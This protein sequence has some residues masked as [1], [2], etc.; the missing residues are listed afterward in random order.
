M[1]ACMR[2]YVYVNIVWCVIII[3]THAHTNLHTSVSIKYFFADVL[4]FDASLHAYTWIEFAFLCLT[5]QIRTYVHMYVILFYTAYIH[6]HHMHTCVREHIL[7][8]VSVCV[9][10]C[11]WVCTCTCVN[12]VHFFIRPHEHPLPSHTHVYN[13]CVYACMLV[14]M[15]MSTVCLVS[16]D[17]VVHVHM[18]VHAST[19]MYVCV[20]V[21]VYIYTHTQAHFHTYIAMRVSIHAALHVSVHIYAQ[22]SLNLPVHIPKPVW[23]CVIL[24]HTHILDFYKYIP[25]C[26]HA[27]TNARSACVYLHTHINAHI[28]TC[29]RIHMCRGATSSLC[30]EHLETQERNDG[31]TS[32]LRTGACKHTFPCTMSQA[33]HQWWCVLDFCG[34][35]C[36]INIV[37]THHTHS[38]VLS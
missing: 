36:V 18:C 2:A 15:Y 23:K 37:L 9:S 20:R 8:C 26:T 5:M 3:Y 1:C 7:T 38:S 28:H 34:L 17:I 6:A 30:L 24:N 13:M 31:L 19:Y 29:S 32:V 33:H 16:C 10:V 14:R 21:C 11:M 22:F 25:T 35:R 4:M 12:T 27:R